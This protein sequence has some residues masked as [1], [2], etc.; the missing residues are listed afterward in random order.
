MDRGVWQA[1]VQRITQSQTRMKRLSTHARIHKGNMPMLVR[2]GLKVQSFYMIKLLSIC[3]L[4]IAKI[5]GVIDLLPQRQQK[6]KLQR[7]HKLNI[8]ITISLNYKRFSKYLA[9]AQ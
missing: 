1:A 7:W 3:H 8:R 6:A 9:S 2:V 4:L 5:Q